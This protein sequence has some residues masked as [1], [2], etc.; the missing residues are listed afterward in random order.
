MKDMLSIE[1]T[2]NYIRD[3]A[4]PH[5]EALANRDY[6]KEFRKSK[7]AMLINE[8]EIKGIK[9]AQQR[10]SYAYANEQYIELLEGLKV[11][12]ERESYLRHQIKAAELRI[13]V[14]RSQ[15]SRQKAEINAYNSKGAM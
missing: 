14:W 1:E 10:E 9:G 11:A 3:K 12:T 15:Y 5:A 2:L 4:Q 7:K 8:A 13:D 6:L